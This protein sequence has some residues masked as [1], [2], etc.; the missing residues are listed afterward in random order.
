MQNRECLR[1]WITQ[2]GLAAT[3]WRYGSPSENTWLCGYVEIPQSFPKKWLYLRY[4]EQSPYDDLKV[5]KGVTYKG[6]AGHGWPGG[7]EGSWIGFDCAHAGDAIAFPAD[8]EASIRYVQEEAERL[9]SQVIALGET[10]EN[11]G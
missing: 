8:S 3:V 1:A 11:R 4:P 9:A 5:H 6:Q 2:A 7:G 10:Y